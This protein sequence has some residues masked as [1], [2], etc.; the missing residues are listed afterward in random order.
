MTVSLFYLY[1]FDIH[2][3]SF[4]KKNVRVDDRKENIVFI[5]TSVNDPC[6][7]EHTIASMSA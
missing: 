1:M 7:F 2:I 6:E 5:S 4:A 3:V